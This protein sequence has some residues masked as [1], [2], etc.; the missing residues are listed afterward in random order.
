MAA[1]LRPAQGLPRTAGARPG[2]AD[3][4]EERRLAVEE[5]VAAAVV[6]APAAVLAA[7]AGV[8]QEGE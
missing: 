5:A 8:S 2:A 4:G 6:V 1:E 7:V 3:P